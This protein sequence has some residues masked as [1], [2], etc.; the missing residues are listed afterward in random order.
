LGGKINT[1]TFEGHRRMRGMGVNERLKWPRILKTLGHPL[2]F[3]IVR[4]LLREE[5]CVHDLWMALDLQQSVVSQ[6]LAILRRGGIV[7]CKR[8]GT[9]VKYFI[10]GKGIRELMNIMDS[11]IS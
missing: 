2:R 1:V 11:G 3:E 8:N 5:K 7:G 10:K 4:H 6:H 9:N